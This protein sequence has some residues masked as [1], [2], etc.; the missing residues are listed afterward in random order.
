MKSKSS[1][2]VKSGMKEYLKSYKTYLPTDKDI[3]WHTDNGGE[4]VSKDLDEFCDEFCV[5]RSF[6]I[7]YAPQTNAQAERIWSILLRSMRITL[8]HG[9]TRII[10]ALRRKTCHISP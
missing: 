6:S 9:C 1:E 3:N 8:A 7:P 10:L 2:E 4:F 5:R